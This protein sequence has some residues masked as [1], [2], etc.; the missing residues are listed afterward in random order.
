MGIRL[1]DDKIELSH[2]NRD[3]LDKHLKKHPDALEHELVD[4][5]PVLT[6]DPKELQVFLSTHHAQ[7]FDEFFPMERAQ[8]G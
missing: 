1:T 6:A 3:W 7:L 2:L 5:E 4:G 8:G